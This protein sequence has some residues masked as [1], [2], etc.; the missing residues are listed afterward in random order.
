MSEKEI[1][2]VIADHLQ[3]TLEPPPDAPVTADTRL[4]D[5]LALDSLQSFELV[6]VLEDQYRLSLSIEV[7]QDVRTVGDV[8]R[9]VA[10]EMARQA[11]R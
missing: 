7:L 3:R 8:A 4:V 1:L 6:A 5:D 11:A 9:A 2:G 10:S